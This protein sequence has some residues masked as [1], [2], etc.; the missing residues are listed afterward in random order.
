MRRQPFWIGFL[1][2]FLLVPLALA[3]CGDDDASDHG[4]GNDMVD[5]TSTMSGGSGMMGSP[6]HA[7]G[8]MEMDMDLMFIDSMIPHHESAIDMAEVAL[9]EAEH[10][11]IKDLAQAIIDAQQSEIDQLRT[12]R[13]AWYAGAA[14]SG[15]MPEMGDMAGMNMTAADLDALRAADPFDQTFIDEMI[16]HHESAITMA[17]EIFS[18]TDRPELKQLAQ[19]IITA[20]RGEIEQMRAWRATWYGQ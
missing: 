14:P 12:W 7:M 9:V 1:G 2:M 10:P 16:P 3:A 4:M 17:E 15:G 8:D 20:Q 5:G 13:N 6:T 18:S 19:D 11:E